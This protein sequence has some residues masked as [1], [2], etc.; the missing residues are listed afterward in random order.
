MCVLESTRTIR[1]G[2]DGAPQILTSEAER[3][4]P[5]ERPQQFMMWIV[6]NIPGNNVHLGN[7]MFEY[8]SPLAIELD[9]KEFNKE[10]SPHVSP[11]LVFEQQERV[12]YSYN[13]FR[14]GIQKKKTLFFVPSLKRHF[15]TTLCRLSWKSPAGDVVQNF[16]VVCKD[17]MILLRSTTSNWWLET[18]SGS[19]GVS[20][21]LRMLS[22]SLPSALGSLSLLER[23]YQ[24]TKIVVRINLEENAFCRHN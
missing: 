17:I 6:T 2:D 14:E 8:I 7:E 11:Y 18:L 21:L 12:G 10:Y 4:P 3:S 23:S 20:V 13:S 24:V 16:W 19:L 1:I 9:G 15:D 5:Q 22:V